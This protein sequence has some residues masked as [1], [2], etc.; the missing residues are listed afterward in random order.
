MVN[1][2]HGSRFEGPENEPTFDALT[3][4]QRARRQGLPGDPTD[5]YGYQ[6]DDEPYCDAD[7]GRSK[8]VA[9]VAKKSD[10]SKRTSQLSIHAQARTWQLPTSLECVDVAANQVLQIKFQITSPEPISFECLPIS[11]IV[12]PLKL[13]SGKQEAILVVPLNFFG[14][15]VTSP[16]T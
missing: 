10:R 8:W 16:A 14:P 12:E 2:S 15:G 3:E 5:P 4:M 1:G 6:L 13:D 11:M 9:R 7:D